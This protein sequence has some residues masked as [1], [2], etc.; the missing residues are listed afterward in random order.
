MTST[1][2]APAAV[3]P[4]LE[5]TGVSKQVGNVR[6]LTTVDLRLYPGEI[7]ALMGQNGAGKSTLIKV[8]TRA[9][10]KRDQGVMRLYGKSIRA[11][12]TLN[13]QH[14]GINTVYQRGQPL[15]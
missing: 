8:L 6:A 5:L 7:H 15:V 2:T 1:P 9:F 3:A 4:A 12:S 10:T 13:A 11:T 14:P